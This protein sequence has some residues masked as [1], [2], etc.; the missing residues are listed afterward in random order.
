MSRTNVAAVVAVA[1]LAIAAACGGNSSGNNNLPTA[2][3]EV[4]AASDGSTLKVPAP[5]LVSPANGAQ[6]P[7][8]T[9]SVT[10]TV[11]NVSGIFASFPITYE[12]ELK[13][14]A[15]ALV[16]NPK[17][18][19]AGGATTSV[20][21]PSLAADTIHSW[22]ARVIY[23]GRVGPWSTPF[24][25]RTGQAAF[26]AGSTVLDPLT[27]GFTV[28]KQR[29]GHFVAGQ[30]W[31]A[32]TVNDGIDY[33]ITTCPNC[34]LEF[35]ATNFG[36][37]LGN[38]GDLKWISMGDAS[39]FF[40]FNTFRDQPYKMTLELRGDFDGTGMKLIWR[41]GTDGSGNP[42]DHEARLDSTG[43]NWQANQVFHFVFDWTPSAYFVSVNGQV[44]FAGSFGGVAYA[45]PNHRIS[46]GCYPRSETLRGTIFRNVT[47]TPR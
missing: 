38:P 12:I 42:G 22:R 19:R 18:S 32:D 33:D 10:L 43:I 41:N 47:V 31:Q 17:V 25:F 37:G 46:L 30:G 24:T 34:R 44:W 39:K 35:D 36:K 40:E 11:S 26:I 3:G 4:G 16:A 7:S 14:S 5:G 20:S 15:G 13:N 2:P 21:V 29:G 23:S 1:A 9:G 45:P 27:T 6:L 8:G 28:G